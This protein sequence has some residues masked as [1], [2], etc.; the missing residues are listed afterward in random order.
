[1]ETRITEVADKIYHLSTYGE[2]A[3]LRFN[4]VLIDADQPLLFHCGMKALFALVS[5]AVS[6]IIPLEKPFYKSQFTPKHC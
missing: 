6:Q 5:G 2:P 3:D 1:M 4:Q